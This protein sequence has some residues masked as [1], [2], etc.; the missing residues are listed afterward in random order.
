[1][2]RGG[3]KE[4]QDHASTG[5]D[6]PRALVLGAS[7]CRAGSGRRWRWRAFMREADILILD[8]P[9]AALDAEAESTPSSSASARS[10]P[11]GDDPDL[12]P[13]PDGARMADRIPV[14]EAGR[15][16]RGRQPRRA[17]SPPA[18]A[19]PPTL[20]PPGRR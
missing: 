18:A 9:T 17:A 11:G 19:T 2:D 12:A 15:A 14:L 5:L 16:D 8:E 3:A 4:L 6:T 20:R 1:V 13:V 7:S 10:P